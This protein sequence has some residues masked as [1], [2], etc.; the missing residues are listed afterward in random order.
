MREAPAGLYAF[1]PDPATEQYPLALISPAS[2]KTVSSMLGELRERPGMLQMHPSDAEARGLAHR[3]S[4]ARLQRS[5]RSA[6]PG[7]RHHERPAGN[8]QPV[9][10]PVAQEH[11]QRL[12]RRTRSRRIR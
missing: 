8:R 11:L 1:Q 4:R 10:G 3:R 6:V 7:R 2:E 5:R 9:E 12:D